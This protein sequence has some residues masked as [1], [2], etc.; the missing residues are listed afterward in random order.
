MS[1]AGL[2]KLIWEAHQAGSDFPYKDEPRQGALYATRLGE[3]LEARGVAWAATGAPNECPKCGAPAVLTH[4]GDE[5]DWTHTPGRPGMLA[6]MMAR[7]SAP[8]PFGHI[9]D[10]AWQRGEIHRANP[11]ELYVEMACCG[12]RYSADHEDSTTEGYSCPLCAPR[13]NLSAAEYDALVRDAMKWR[14]ALGSAP[15]ETLEGAK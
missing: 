10:P 1:D 8:E 2:A 11:N 7:A 6:E 13:H 15:R 9:E 3:W 14:A 4:P 12:F 5:R